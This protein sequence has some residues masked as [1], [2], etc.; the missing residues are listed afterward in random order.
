MSLQSLY[1]GRSQSSV[2]HNRRL[3]NHSAR[4]FHWT[5]LSPLGGFDV[6]DKHASKQALSYVILITVSLLAA[7]PA[8]FLSSRR[9]RTKADTRL[10][11]S[12]RVD[13]NIPAHIARSRKR[14]I[15]VGLSVPSF[16]TEQSLRIY[17]TL[18]SR[19]V[20]IKII[21][22][23]P[24][25]PSLL[26]RPPKLYYGHPPPSITAAI[27]LKTLVEYSGK[28]EPSKANN[29]EIRVISCL[30]TTATIIV[31]DECLWH[32]YLFNSTG[33]SSPY[34]VESALSGY[35]AHVLRYAEELASSAMSVEA[36]ADADVLVSNVRQTPNLRFQMS[37]D[38]I[39]ATRKALSL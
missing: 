15:V 13:L 10:Y 35:G 29:F 6:L 28:L 9:Y 8:S 34:L 25:S 16:A 27:T 37:A 2:S 19:G 1:D 32:P 4:D 23:N 11:G 5:L 22:V 20:Q 39:R 38:E 7:A 12:S 26:Q 31:D 21:L 14:M 3:G 36:S 17:D 24:F 33:V 30:P 18:L